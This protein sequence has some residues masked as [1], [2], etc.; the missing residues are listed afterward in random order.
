[1]RDSTAFG[2]VI[3]IELENTLGGGCGNHLATTA[4]ASDRAAAAFHVQNPSGAIVHDNLVENNNLANFAPE[5]TARI[6]R[7]RASCSSV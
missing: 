4:T 6:C 3:G 5:A 2:N 7:G 1:V